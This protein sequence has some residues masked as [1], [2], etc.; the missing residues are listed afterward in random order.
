MTV[1]SSQTSQMLSEGFASDFGG[2]DLGGGGGGLGDFLDTLM[3]NMGVDTS[4]KATQ[5][6]LEQLSNALYGTEDT[7]GGEDDVPEMVI[8]DTKDPADEDV[9]EMVITDTK[10]PEDDVPEMVITDTKDP[11][12]DTTPDEPTTTDD[13]IIEPTDDIVHHDVEP[14]IDPDLPPDTPVV[15]TPPVVTPP[16]VEGG[17]PAPKQASG[18]AVQNLA[19]NPAAGNATG[20]SSGAMPGVADTLLTTFDTFG[21]GKPGMGGGAAYL[22]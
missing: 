22:S 16:P 12:D 10:L 5:T 7:G 6:P 17:G 21:Y 19:G 18:D 1:K 14:P 8:T 13:P 9:P 11:L 15:V 2:F 4:D 3:T 20:G